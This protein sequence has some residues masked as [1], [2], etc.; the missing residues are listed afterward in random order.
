MNLNRLLSGMPKWARKEIATWVAIFVTFVPLLFLRTS[1][2]LTA[3]LALRPFLGRW[4]LDGAKMVVV[5]GGLL[6]FAVVHAGLARLFGLEWP[7]RDDARSGAT[8][9]ANR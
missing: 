4:A 8:K 7:F 9:S 3:D 6:A 2:F 5:G 1:W